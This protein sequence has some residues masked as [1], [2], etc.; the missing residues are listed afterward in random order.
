MKCVDRRFTSGD[1]Y[2]GRKDCE[3][4]WHCDRGLAR[5]ELAKE[6]IPNGFGK[7]DGD[8]YKLSL[9]VTVLKFK[10]HNI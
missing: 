5:E 9:S 4:A 7:A 8:F 3:H 6:N 2:K 1:W 10:V